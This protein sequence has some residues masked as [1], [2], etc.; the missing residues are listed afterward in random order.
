MFS[1]TRFVMLRCRDVANGVC[2]IKAFTIIRP[3][4]DVVVVSIPAVGAFEY[5][6]QKRSCE[7]YS[8]TMNMMA[9]LGTT[10]SKCGPSPAYKPRKP[11]CRSTVELQCRRPL[12]GTGRSK[13]SPP[14]KFFCSLNR[15]RMRSCGY[16]ITQAENLASAD[17]NSTSTVA[18]GR[19]S[20]CS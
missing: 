16:A 9:V 2:A 5:G 12:Y 15:V 10:R 3:M 17:A 20:S 8:N 18:G 14:I 7:R 11:S 13:G 6:I 4:S 1:Y 19:G